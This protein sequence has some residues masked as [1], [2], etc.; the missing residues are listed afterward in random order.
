M[1][2]RRYLYACPLIE[3]WAVVEVS[4]EHFGGSRAEALFIGLAHQFD[5]FRGGHAVAGLDERFGIETYGV[6][7]FCTAFADRTVDGLGDNVGWSALVQLRFKQAHQ[8]L[9]CES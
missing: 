1:I 4:P 8:P 9:Q 3:R 2:S 5:P 6:A 7:Q